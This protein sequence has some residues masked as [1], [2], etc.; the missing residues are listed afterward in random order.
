[1]IDSLWKQ[2]F[3]LFAIDT[4]LIVIFL[5]TPSPVLLVSPHAAVS[6]SQPMCE[7]FDVETLSRITVAWAAL[8][9]AWFV[10]KQVKTLVKQPTVKRQLPTSLSLDV[11][12]TQ[13]FKIQ[14]RAGNQRTVPLAYENQHIVTMLNGLDPYGD[15]FADSFWHNRAFSS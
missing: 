11:T 3:L 5:S 14:A 15:C 10:C 4:V 13:P 7:L 1:M 6:S 2:P 8:Q 9:L 12:V